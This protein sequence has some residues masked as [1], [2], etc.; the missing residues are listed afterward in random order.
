MVIKNIERYVVDKSTGFAEC[1]LKFNKL[2]GSKILLVVDEGALVG[3][4]GV[5]E[6]KNA[7]EN[8]KPSQL[9]AINIANKHFTSVIQSENTISECFKLFYESNINIIPIITSSE[10]L[11]TGLV[12]RNDFIEFRMVCFSQLID[13]EVVLNYVMLNV[14]NIY[15]IDV[16]AFDPWDGNI[17]KWLSF[18]RRGRGIN[19][20]PQLDYYTLLENDRPNDININTA[21]GDK[22]GMMEMYGWGPITTAVKEYA[23]NKHESIKVPVTTLSNVCKQ[24]VPDSQEIH[25]LK[26]DVEGYEKQVLLGADLVNY[27]PWIICI[28]STIPQTDIPTQGEWEHIL[29]N[30]RYRFAKQYGVNRFY[31]AK[32]HENFLSRFIDI[33]DI[34]KRMNV[35][36]ALGYK[37]ICSNEIST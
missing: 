32:E 4:I 33:K 34:L 15:Y 31:V 21:L 25:F 26:I 18:N 16:G 36:H 24:Y 7:L 14:P 9:S 23:S 30:A 28:E 35:Y 17:T 5:N 37:D 8:S 29:L 12:Q 20:E 2:S 19:I 6:I 10:N 27:R 11:P 3:V 22:E 1:Y 13:E